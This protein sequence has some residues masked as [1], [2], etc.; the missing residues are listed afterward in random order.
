MLDTFY[1][2]A[3][4]SLIKKMV[5]YIQV[6]LLTEVMDQGNFGSQIV[7]VLAMVL[8]HEVS[9]PMG[10]FLSK[11]WSPMFDHLVNS[12]FQH[13]ISIMFHVH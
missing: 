5:H 10:E 1:R 6:S 8:D 11:R 2:R 7:E 9:D 12:R 3:S 4:L 13:Q